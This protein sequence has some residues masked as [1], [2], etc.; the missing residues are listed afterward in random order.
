MI[1]MDEELKYKLFEY[2]FNDNEKKAFEAKNIQLAFK[3]NDIIMDYIRY[4]VNS[5]LY[6]K[7]D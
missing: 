6:K 2:K 1:I 5:P 4:K 7:V 3:H